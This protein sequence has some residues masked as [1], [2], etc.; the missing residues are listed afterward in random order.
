MENIIQ[1]CSNILANLDKFT[2]VSVVDDFKLSNINDMYLIKG[3]C[4]NK[5]KHYEKCVWNENIIK[6][7]QQDNIDDI[8]VLDKISSNE[9]TQRTILNTKTKFMNL[10]QYVKVERMQRIRN[11]N[12]SMVVTYIID[13]TDDA[14]EDIKAL[15]HIK[16]GWSVMKFEDIDGET[17]LTFLFKYDV[18]IPECFRNVIG[19]KGLQSVLNISKQ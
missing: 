8:V 1:E 10:G 9:K 13:D 15:P 3:K 12:T 4:L 18:N 14:D 19:I 16:D 6:H 11:E 2:E 7:I 5:A 17:Y